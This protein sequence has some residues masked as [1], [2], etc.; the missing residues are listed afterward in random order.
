MSLLLF[1]ISP[2]SFIVSL[3][4][5]DSSPFTSFFH[6]LHLPPLSPSCITFT[7]HLYLHVIPLEPFSLLL[8]SFFISLFFD[9][10]FAN[11]NIVLMAN[12]NTNPA[13]TLLLPSDTPY[14]ITQSFNFEVNYYY[15]FLIYVAH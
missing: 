12:S 6:N 8:F 15:C 13:N 14:K 9:F 1:S 10:F 3:L 7:S 11:P 5:L 2:D 4:S